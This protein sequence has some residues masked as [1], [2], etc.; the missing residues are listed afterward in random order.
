MLILGARM[1]IGEGQATPDGPQPSFREGPDRTPTAY[2]QGDDRH[3]RD[4]YEVAGRGRW[5]VVRGGTVLPMTGAAPLPHHDILIRDGIIEAVQPSSADVPADAL[6]IDAASRFTMPGLT[7]IH[8][9]PPLRHITGMYA[10]MFG[11]HVTGDDITLPYDLMMFQYLAAGITRLQ[12]MAGSPE[13]LA[14]RAAIRSGRYRGPHMRIASPVI[15]SPAAIW[16]SA[17]TWYA[18]DAE[19]GRQAARAI[20]EQGYD[21]AKPYTTL[22]REAYF[23]LVEECKA[24]GI[25]VMGHVPASVLPEEA[26][27]AGQ[28]GV[29][30]CFEYFYHHQG[31]QRFSP[32]RVAERVRLSRDH[33]VTLQTTLQIARVYEYDCGLIPASDINFNDNLDPM[34]R[35]IMREDSAFIQGWRANP[36]LMAAAD[37]IF[38]YSTQMCQALQAEG[39]RL[40]PGTD[41]SPS[42]ITGDMSLHHELRTLVERGVMSPIEVLTAATAVAAEYQGEGA[43]AGTIEPG[44]RSDLIV[45]AADPTADIA[46]TTTIDTVILGDAILS[47]AARKRGLARLAERYGAMPIA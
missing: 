6:V 39:V 4:L 42:S 8:Q 37:N 47:S 23:A 38:D 13:D 30:H 24:L 16:S 10:G 40:L 5:V 33:G 17:I 26:F 2:A 28:T 9:H 15:D 3:T 27:K 45:L 44:K 25:E 36:V 29:A 1:A 34:I 20:I 32:E 46:N 22:G 43:T 19:G 14:N 31:E 11:E 35:S 41:M 7:D 18:N 12:V 21:H